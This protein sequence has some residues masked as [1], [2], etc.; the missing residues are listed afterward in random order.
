M[1]V[2]DAGLDDRDDLRT[3]DFKVELVAEMFGDP[4]GYDR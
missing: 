3:W 4:E 1:G 2:L